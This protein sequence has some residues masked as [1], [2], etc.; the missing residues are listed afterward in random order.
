MRITPNLDVS[1]TILL[2]GLRVFG[3]DRIDLL[4]HTGH[5][6]G[7]VDL[8]M[9]VVLPVEFHQRESHRMVLLESLAEG[10]LIVIRPSDE[11]FSGDI[12]SHG[13]LGWVELN[14]IRPSR[15]DMEE[16]AS[17]S[18]DEKLI[19]DLELD[20]G[21]Q[22]SFP[23]LEKGVQLFSLDGGTRE[24]IE[25]ESLGAGRLVEIR[26]D[27]LTDD[28]ISDEFSLAHDLSG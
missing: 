4:R 27:H 15:G 26:L 14:V 10:S 6:L 16:S 25:D 8:V 9:E 17:D 3:E 1:D 23:L 24:S 22:R 13:K 20:H 21:I 18:S 2:V 12:V 19:V 11:G 5:R 7:R 28:L